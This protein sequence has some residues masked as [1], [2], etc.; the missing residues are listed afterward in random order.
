MKDQQQFIF[1]IGGVPVRFFRGDSESPPAHNLEVAP[2]AMQ[3]MELCYGHENP[4]DLIWR[5]AIETNGL[6]EVLRIVL[7]GAHTEGGVDFRFVIPPDETLAIF[8]PPQ[9]PVRRGITL[10]A[11]SVTVLAQKRASDTDSNDGCGPKV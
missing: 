2:E 6:G 4:F 11:P 3:Q 5:I 9:M 1:A 10:P 7:I 8:V